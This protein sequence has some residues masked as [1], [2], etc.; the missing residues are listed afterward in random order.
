MR[1]SPKTAPPALPNW[2]RRFQPAIPIQNGKSLRTLR[3]AATFITELPPA[4][5]KAEQWQL[6]AKLLLMVAER[7]G[8]PMLPR[9]A[10]MKALHHREATTEFSA[11][12]RRAKSYRIIG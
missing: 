10:V 2:L 1:T 4:E 5:Q 12:R 8:D 3:E 7:G 9:I 11:R 6:A